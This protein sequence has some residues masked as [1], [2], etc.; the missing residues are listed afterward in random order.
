MSAGKTELTKYLKIKSKSLLGKCF[1]IIEDYEEKVS[2]SKM[3]F[4]TVNE[5][6]EYLQRTDL[7]ADLCF[8]DFYIN[9]ISKI[10]GSPSHRIYKTT[11]NHL[12]KYK[13]RIFVSEI[14][15]K[16]L[17]GFENYLSG[18]E[19]G[20]RGVSLYMSRIRAVY[21]AM[22]DEYQDFGYKFNYPFRKY[23]VPTSKSKKTIAISKENLTKIIQSDLQ[24]R[25]EFSRDMFAI[26]LFSCGT[27]ATDLYDLKES[28]NGRIE[29]N[30]NKTKGRRSDE[31]FISIRIEPELLPYIEKYKGNNGYMFNFRDLYKNRVQLVKAIG[32]GIK[33]ICEKLE[34]PKFVYYDARRTMASVMRNKLKISKDDIAMCLNHVD[35][36]HKIT[37]IYIETDFSIIDDCNRKFIDWIFE[38]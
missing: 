33:Q 4:N 7:S 36:E 25:A 32:E 14:T 11:Y 9:F 23:K 19:M 27:N 15:P 3:E 5:V 28:E 2:K 18:T 20:D 6:S 8:T 16:F 13:N 21:N 38:D 35:M 22:V 34:I 24:G 30:R 1:Q 31:A 17:S 37:D 12:T 29:Y 10:S 26:S